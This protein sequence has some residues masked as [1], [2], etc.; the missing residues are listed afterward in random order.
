MGASKGSASRDRRSHRNAGVI[1]KQVAEARTAIS[2]GGA[3]EERIKQGL[4][5]NDDDGWAEELRPL[6]AKL[7]SSGPP[8]YSDLRGRARRPLLTNEQRADANRHLIGAV[9]WMIVGGMI[10]VAVLAI[11]LLGILKTAG[12]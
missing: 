12:Y 6:A 2:I 5:L 11:A 3:I 1:R 4:P 9:Y 8:D 10:A 7:M